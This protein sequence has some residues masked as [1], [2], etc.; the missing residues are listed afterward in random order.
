MNGGLSD[1]PPNSGICGC[2]LAKDLALMTILKN[3]WSLSSGD[4]TYP[5]PDPAVVFGKDGQS[6]FSKYLNNSG[7]WE[8]D[9]GALR[10]QAIDFLIEELSKPTFKEKV[11]AKYKL[12]HIMLFKLI[13]GK[14]IGE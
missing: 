2:L 4:I 1:N 8:G 14:E 6:A 9:Y 5:I 12:V 11:M 10:I 3:K 13:T 7:Y